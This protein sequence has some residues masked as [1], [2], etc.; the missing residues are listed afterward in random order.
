MSMLTNYLKTG[1]RNLRR[2][3]S[4]SLI[5]ILGL[6]LGMT[7]F[8]L[9]I[10]YAFVQLSY[11]DYHEDADRLY[12]VNAREDGERLVRSVGSLGPNVLQSIPQVEAF[13][14]FD[15]VNGTVKEE[16]ISY[17]EENIFRVDPTFFEMFD[18]PMVT[19]VGDNPLA[20]PE[21][22]VLSQSLAR[23]YFGSEQA[24]GKTLTFNEKVYEVTAIAEDDTR[25]HIQFDALISIP[26]NEVF[27]WEDFNYFTYLKLRE[28]ANPDD[29]SRSINGLFAQ[30]C[31]GETCNFVLSVMPLTDIYL[32]SD[33]QLE[34][35]V[36]GD[37][38]TVRYLIIF[39]FIVLLIAWF[40]YVSLSTINALNRGREI[41]TRLAIGSSRGAVVIQFLTEYLMMNLVV[42][43]LAVILAFLGAD[44]ISRYLGVII[45]LDIWSSTRFWIFYIGIFILGLGLSASYPAFIMS[46]FNIIKALKSNQKGDNKGASLRRVLTTAQ[47]VAAVF[48]IACTAISY[49]QVRFVQNQDLG[50]DMEQVLSVRIAERISGQ[51][52]DLVTLRD[53]IKGLA[54]VGE[55]AVASSIPGSEIN[56][57]VGD[58][59]HNET[60]EPQSIKMIWS[61][62]QFT[63]VFQ[64][65]LAQG[66][67]RLRELKDSKAP[68]F[69][70]NEKGAEMLGISDVENSQEQISLL[71]GNVFEVAGIVKDYYQRSAKSPIEPIL[72]SAWDL[73]GFPITGDLNYLI[74]I[75][76]GSI[77]ATVGQVEA[78][79]NQVFPAE[80]F[81]FSFVDDTYNRQFEADQQMINLFT[82]FTLLAVIISGMGLFAL[83][84]YTAL[85]RTKEV[86]LRKV[87][88]ATVP[89]LVMIFVVDVVKLVAI[90]SL[91]GCALAWYSM[92]QW[93]ASFA[94]RIGFEWWWYLLAAVLVMAFAILIVGYHSLRVATISPA[95]SLKDE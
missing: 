69:L 82:V 50:F 86:A 42:F 56:F 67:D 16:D 51:K 27:N 61:D 63:D 76:G 83:T 44:L 14:R 46:R 94:I 78:A 21:G 9:M 54:S 66:E 36:I 45:P 18:F 15:K 87:L 10:Q 7:V 84:L 37:G 60:D 89:S 93:M 81:D 58:V 85:K 75:S 12:R 2:N 1:L 19:T 29:V 70:L 26:E 92:D 71:G 24:I 28:G 17:F 59:K 38:K 90:A 41:G 91:V 52:S 47:F 49:R 31:L 34:I 74:R 53:E 62:Y 72:I 6:S 64:M 23:K 13:T 68:V 35:G 79:W 33:L 30:N 8:I 40:N 55:V 57:V 5:N 25:S 32:N 88:G 95:R 4:Y 43:V 11:D 77:S 20:R 73:G 39:A 22:M 65:E 80:P 48:L 3:L